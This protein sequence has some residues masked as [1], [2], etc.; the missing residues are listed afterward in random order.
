MGETGKPKPRVY[1]EVT[2]VWGNG[3]AESTIRISRR[4]W[5]RI[6]EGQGFETGAWGWYE[7]ERF[8]VVWSFSG[9][10]VSIHGPGGGDHIVEESVDRLFHGEVDY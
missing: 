2:A 8:R 6:Q 4:R 5:R 10:L 1:V 3:D 7:G 9:G